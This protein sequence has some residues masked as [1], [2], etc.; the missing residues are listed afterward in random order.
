MSVNG[1][2][3]RLPLAYEYLGREEACFEPFKE[4]TWRMPST[5]FANL[6]PLVFIEERSWQG[7]LACIYNRLR[8]DLLGK[9]FFINDGDDWRPSI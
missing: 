8:S 3:E 2:G 6:S 7:G 1:I 4:W 5:I 9:N